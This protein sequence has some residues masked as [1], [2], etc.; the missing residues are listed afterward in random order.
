LSKQFGMKPAA[1]LYVEEPL[2]PGAELA[3]REGQAHYLRSVLRLEPGRRVLLFNGR[4]GEWLAEIAELRKS[5]G[6]ATALSQR[7]AQEHE[8]DLWLLFAPIK[9]DRIDWIAEKATELGAARLQPVM[10]RHTVVTR[11]N[12]ERL[13]AR[14]VEAAEQCERLTVPE[15]LELRP[16]REALQGWPVERRLFACA[17]AGP[18]RPL[19]EVLAAGPRN[20]P[21]GL[22][23][24]PEGGF[25]P[26]ELDLLRELAFVSAVGLG[27]RLLRAD[28]A[29]IAALAL[30]QALAGDGDRRP[31]QRFE[32]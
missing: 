6:A 16:L 5:G 20:G 22:L 12:V 14:A 7:R 21:S 1:R 10:T 27:P 32:N 25:S 3:L 23:I 29:A 30:W 2:A 26:D 24:G 18:A 4:D 8:P 19:A 11:V 28:T 9:G 15:V 17:E 13:R 31:P